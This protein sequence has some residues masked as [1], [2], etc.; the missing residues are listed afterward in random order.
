[1][2]IVS[3]CARHLQHDERGGEV[4]YGDNVE[5][6]IEGSAYCERGIGTRPAGVDVDGS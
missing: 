5:I 4:L 1:M 3:C 6:G 2:F